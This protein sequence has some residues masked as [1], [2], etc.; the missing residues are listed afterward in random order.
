MFIILY[1]QSKSLAIVNTGTYRNSHGYI[2]FHK[3][4]TKSQINVSWTLA[5]SKVVANFV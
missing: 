1:Y 2:P 5:P 4:C 3:S